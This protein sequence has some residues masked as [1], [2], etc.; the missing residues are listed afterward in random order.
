MNNKQLHCFID[1]CEHE[2]FLSLAKSLD[3]N[4]SQLMRKLV[5]DYV[6]KYS[7]TRTRTLAPSAENIDKET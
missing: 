7:A 4:A 3:L 2:A 5:R 6:R 1:E